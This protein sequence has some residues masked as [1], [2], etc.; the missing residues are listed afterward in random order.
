[1]G[2]LP[3]VNVG[4]AQE[5]SMRL[6]LD[7]KAL[8]LLKPTMTPRQYIEALLEDKQYLAGI[9]FV[10]H[11]L[12][13]RE[14]IWWGCLCLQHVCGD[15]LP[16]PD[17]SAL[18]AAVHWV[19]Q[20]SDAQRVAAKRPADALGLSSP[21]GA[22]ATAAS[23]TGG[24]LAP[25]GVPVVPP[26]PWAPARAVAIAVKVASTKSDPREITRTQRSLIELGVAVAEGRFSP[27]SRK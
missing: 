3:L 23:Q 25:P 9:D 11:A 1:M 10:A 8:Q 18:R 19:L 17:K 7:K 15:T 16:G 12:P 24:S 22:L 26:S 13:T 5:V 2:A 14:S 21:A 4:T 6:Y 27:A 20:P